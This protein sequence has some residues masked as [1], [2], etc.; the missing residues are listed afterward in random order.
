MK[1][2]IRIIIDI[3]MFILFIILMGYHITG[4]NIHEILGVITFLFFILHHIVNIK[5]Y[6]TIFKG[7][8]NAYRIFMLIINILLF[9]FMIGIIISS[10]MISSNVFSFLNIRTTM[11]GRNLHMVSTSWAFVLMGIHL[12]LHLNIMLNRLTKRAKNSAFEYVYYLVIFLLIIFGVYA[13]IDNELWKDMFLVNEFK[14]FDYNENHLIFYIKTLAIA[15]SISFITYV[16][17]KVVR[18]YSKS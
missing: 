11:F 12:G 7:K 6:K 18:R 13:F 3:I 5:W 4:N 14:F 1:K 17:L 2:Y 15:L 16:I 10:I 8:Y 9:I